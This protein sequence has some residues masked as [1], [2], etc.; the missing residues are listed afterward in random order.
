MT[1]T[2]PSLY[3]QYLTERCGHAILETDD[4]FVT[5]EMAERLS[6]RRN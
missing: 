1:I 6:A 3:A 5:Y 4:G 2:A